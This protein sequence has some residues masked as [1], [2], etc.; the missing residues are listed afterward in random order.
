[1]KNCLIVVILIVSLAAGV[2]CWKMICFGPDIQF[3]DFEWRVDANDPN[4]SY[5]IY[6][7]N[8]VLSGYIEL[9]LC[10]G[11]IV[12]LCTGRPYYLNKKTGEL[13]MAQDSIEISKEI[14]VRV[15]LANLKTYYDYKNM[16]TC[17]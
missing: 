15:D 10:N 4:K 12:G 1:M 14:G 13:K 16:G 3:C 6:D 11:S 17:Q 9:K 2:S 8:V 5:L 7:G